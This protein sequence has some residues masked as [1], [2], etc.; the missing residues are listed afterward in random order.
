MACNLISY[1]RT[2]SGA[3]AARRSACSMVAAMVAAVSHEDLE[4]AHCWLEFDL[5]P[6]EPEVTEFR[7]AVRYHNAMWR[8]ANGYPIGTHRNR[9]G[10]PPRLV[11][12]RLDLDFARQ[13]GSTFLTTK[14]LAAARDRTSFVERHQM[15]DHQGFWADLLSSEALAV[16][17][18]G[19]LAADLDRA[20]R[21]VHTWWPASPGRVT[22][23]RFAHSPGRF[24]PN[25]SNSLR[26][27]DA[28]FVLTL[29]D[30]SNGAL[31]I[32]VK[33]REV[34]QR[35]GAK[36]THL[37]RFVEIHDRSAVFAP[38]AADVFNKSRLTIIWLEHLLLLS[39]LQHH[40]GRWTWGRYVMVHPEGNRDVAHATNEYRELLADDATFTSATI[41]DLLSAKVLAPKTGA[42]LRRRYLP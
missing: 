42:A 12:S 31:A 19:D 13:S 11:G 8:E 22:E 9:P 15:F 24:D 26:C 39:M 16:N 32:D 2:A 14:A 17:L 37:P 25:Y 40:S 36:P 6:G 1:R 21:A 41:E 10:T 30:G 28:V 5:V 23:V 38:G 4:A 7:R 34:V 33:Y 18:F 3:R 20:D 29:P 35:E 27:F